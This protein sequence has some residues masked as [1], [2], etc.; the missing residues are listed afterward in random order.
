LCNWTV[1]FHMNFIALVCID[2]CQ[3]T[4]AS[5]FFHLLKYVRKRANFWQETLMWAQIIVKL[6]KK[7]FLAVYNLNPYICRNYD[8][9]ISVLKYPMTAS[10]STLR[11][12]FI[13]ID[14]FSI[15]GQTLTYFYFVWSCKYFCFQVVAG[16]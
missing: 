2:L 16:S 11:R 3:I 13:L 7:Y 12:H 5:N 1:F 4:F 9:K 8:Q 10:G 14:H 15:H 6:N